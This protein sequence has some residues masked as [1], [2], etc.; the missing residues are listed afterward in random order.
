MSLRRDKDRTQ[1]YLEHHGQVVV[2][3][4]DTMKMENT[5]ITK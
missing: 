1:T 3:V 4:A 5:F 2:V